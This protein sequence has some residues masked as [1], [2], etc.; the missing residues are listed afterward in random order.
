MFAKGL[1]R[2]KRKSH[3]VGYDIEWCPKC[4]KHLLPVTSRIRSKIDRY[5]SILAS[6]AIVR[7]ATGDTQERKSLAHSDFA[8]HDPHTADT[9]RNR[10]EPR[11]LILSLPKTYILEVNFRQFWPYTI[12]ISQESI[13]WQK[14]K[15]HKFFI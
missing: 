10:D 9:I 14:T 7:D 8:V 1:F 2:R 12:Q 5:A 3:V 13:F 4:G 6:R 15:F 11:T